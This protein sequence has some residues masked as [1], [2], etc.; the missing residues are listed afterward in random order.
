MKKL[1][2]LALMVGVAFAQAPAPQTSGGTLEQTTLD[3]INYLV[4][5]SGGAGL[6][7]GCTSPG[8]GAITCTGAFIGGSLA[9]SGGSVSAVSILT[10]H[11]TCGAVSTPA[12]G[13]VTFFADSAASDALSV[14]ISAGT[15]S[16][17]G[18]GTSTNGTNGQGLTSNGAG[19]F[20]TPVTLAASAT[21]DTTNGANISSG[22]IPAARINGLLVA[23]QVFYPESYGAL[24]DNSHDDTTAIQSAITAAGAVNG[25][26]R[27]QAG[28]YKVTAPLTVPSYVTIEGVSDVA[29]SLNST[30]TTTDIIQI[31][32]T[33]D[34]CGA[35]SKF[36]ITLKNFSVQRVTQA[37][38]GDGIHL[39]DTCYVT[40]DHV[41]SFDSKNNV[42][43]SG[44]GN[45]H[46]T[47]GY[48]GWNTPSTT[49]VRN[50]Y[51]LDSSAHSNQSTIFD[52]HTVSNG[53]GANA[54]GMM[55]K[56]A[57]IADLFVYGFET[58]AIDYGVWVESTLGAGIT[59]SNCNGDIHLAQQIHD[60]IGIAGITVKNVQSHGVPS[61]I[62]TNSYF[63]SS[64]SGA[65]GV[66][67]IGSEGV[68][69]TS[70]QF[71]LIGDSSVC[72]NATTT[73]Y[74][75]V[76]GNQFQYC[77]LGVLLDQGY[78]SSVT[79]NLFSGTAP[80]TMSAG[81][82]TTG[83]G[84]YHVFTGNIMAGNAAD[85]IAVGVLLATGT[86][87]VIAWPNSYGPG[88][89]TTPAT[90]ADGSSAIGGVTATGTSCAITK[91]QFGVI[92]AATCTP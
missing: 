65:F 27:L 44:A 39:V 74:S 82:K 62:V 77:R 11:T 79:G 52:G 32:G 69:V 88:T 67:A 14:K 31:V 59:Y 37:T 91:I 1:L 10:T 36:W 92:T 83:V 17:V 66:S 42:Y 7:T 48:A 34:N 71:Q 15:C 3:T 54:T 24:R 22:V 70:S 68:S 86:A 75:I 53:G 25:T 57:C 23:P 45:T 29:T 30:S 61:V 33:D 18:G 87:S 35:A 63:Q 8:T 16:A 56:G 84:G 6:P 43:L 9:A 13:K 19:A 51:F 90:D 21:T 60:R 28:Q 4:A 85:A 81:I 55:V 2:T 73:S 5:H 20:G 89:V 46:I 50:G 41:Y 26:V 49:V 40:L 38:A 58:A 64:A 72:F 80:A 12:S 78:L 76:S 47:S